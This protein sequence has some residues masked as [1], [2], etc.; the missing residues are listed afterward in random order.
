[1]RKNAVTIDGE[2]SPAVAGPRQEA[3]IGSKSKG[4]DHVFARRPKLFR[5]A[6]GADAVDAAGEQSRKRNERLLRGSLAGTRWAAGHNGWRA[7]WVG[8]DG[9]RSLPNAL[10]LDRKST[11]LNSS[12]S[13]ISYA[14]FCLKKKKKK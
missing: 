10:L 7:L 11:R 13:S 4:V 2:E 3:A 6:I 9:A 12:H 5:G 1:M 8:D 14:V